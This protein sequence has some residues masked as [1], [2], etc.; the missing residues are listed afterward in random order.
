MRRDKE[1]IMNTKRTDKPKRRWTAVDTL[2][3]LLVLL[4]VAGLVYRV[5]YAAQKKSSES[6]L[7]SV[8]FEVTEV[9]EDVLAEIE[10][11]DAVYLYENGVRLGYI[12]MHQDTVTGERSVFQSISPAPGASGDNRVTAKGCMFCT[13]A[14]VS[15]GGG[16]RIGESGRVL[17][18]GSELEIRTDRARLTIRNTS[19][20]E[21]FPRS[22][23]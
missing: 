12:G 20:N 14:T 10:G 11:F 23:V 13:N 19:I 15:A 8:Y 16:L 6:T 18:P 5:V 4:S 9:H 22:V 17:V 7:Y 3:L 21:H 2:I 1:T